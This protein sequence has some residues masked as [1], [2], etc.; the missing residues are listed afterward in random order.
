MSL[1]SCIGVTR[2]GRPENPQFAAPQDRDEKH[3]EALFFE[4]EG[5]EQHMDRNVAKKL[6]AS[7]NDLSTSILF[8]KRSP[9]WDMDCSKFLLGLMTE[10]KRLKDYAGIPGQ[11]FEQT[12]QYVHS[13]SEA[14]A[15]ATETFQARLR[16]QLNIVGIIG[17]SSSCDFN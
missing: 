6:T 11:Q 4:K 12:L 14:L 5:E 15:E 2:A 1:E 9:K 13:Y 10:S 17:Y 3:N 7:I 8:T 16:L